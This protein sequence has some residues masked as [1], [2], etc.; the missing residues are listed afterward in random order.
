MTVFLLNEDTLTVKHNCFNCGEEFEFEYGY[1][2]ICPKCGYNQSSWE[3]YVD[4]D[5]S[6]E[7]YYEDEEEEEDEHIGEIEVYCSN[8]DRYVYVDEVDTVC[9]ICDSKLD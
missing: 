9:P 4:E 2:G 3:T 1:I 6:S 5:N 7:E 8:C